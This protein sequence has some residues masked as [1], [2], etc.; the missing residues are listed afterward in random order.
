MS[1]GRRNGDETTVLILRMAATQICP[2]VGVRIEAL[3]ASA[4]EAGK[5]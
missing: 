1:R 5:D 4:A 3:S 2:P